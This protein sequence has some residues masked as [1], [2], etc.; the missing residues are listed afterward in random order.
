MPDTT[1]SRSP[2]FWSSFVRARL[3]AAKLL[4]TLKGNL[5]GAIDALEEARGELDREKAAGG[6]DD[7]EARAEIEKALEKFQAEFGK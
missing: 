4:G 5:R 1:A 6:A 2:S 7:P 3:E